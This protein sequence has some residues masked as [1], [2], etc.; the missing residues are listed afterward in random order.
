MRAAAALLLTLVPPSLA[1]QHS[2]EDCQKACAH[3]A[4]CCSTAIN[5]GSNQHLSCLQAC[6]VRVRG[7]HRAECEAHCQTR[8]C[9]LRINGFTY[10][11]CQSCTD[12]PSQGGSND[13][14]GTY[15]RC[16]HI[17]GASEDTCRAGCALG[18]DA[19]AQPPLPPPAAVPAG[20]CCQRSAS[21]DRCATW[22]YV[23]GNCIVLTAHT[24]SC[25]TGGAAWM[26]DK[27]FDEASGRCVVVGA[28]ASAGTSPSL[29]PPPPLPPPSPYFLAAGG[30][31]CV[32]ACATRAQ[33]CDLPRVT[34][35]AASVAQCRAVVSALGVTF[36]KSGMYPDDDS[37]CTYH[38]G[39][40]GWA[41]VMHTGRDQG[42][43]PAPTCAV[44]NRDRARRRVCACAARSPPL[45]SAPPPP[46]PVP[47]ARSAGCSCHSSNGARDE[48]YCEGSGIVDPDACDSDPR[49]HWGPFESRRCRAMVGR[50]EPPPPPQPGAVRIAVVHE[51]TVAG[52]LASFDAFAVQALEAAVRRTFPAALTVSLT[53]SA[54]SVRVRAKL[55]LPSAAEAQLAHATLARHSPASLSALLGITILAVEPPSMHASDAAEAGVAEEVGAAEV[56][57]SLLG[58]DASASSG[59][60]WAAANPLLLGALL[61]SAGVVGLVAA[62]AVLFAIRRRQRRAPTAAEGSMATSATTAASRRAPVRVQARPRHPPPQRRGAT[63]PVPVV[64]VAQPVVS[65]GTKTAGELRDLSEGAAPPPYKDAY[66]GSQAD[67]CATALALDALDVLDALPTDDERLSAG[68]CDEI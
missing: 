49:C 30:E 17:Y 29:A 34:A 3:D 2:L 12:V 11:R 26:A 64:V 24:I 41:Q 58:G 32:A 14:G 28:A 22:A 47:P 63:V 42:T 20:G 60:G 46:P 51:W 21:D 9:E 44:V 45:A 35:A 1:G 66:T 15:S 4:H 37:G 40:T 61:C 18:P 25:S 33:E 13:Y 8:G 7:T 67:C 50:L 54:A 48:A 62:A 5:P 68:R 19:A 56:E 57:M 43:V 39:Q 23:Y 36:T 65:D 16:S 59:A 31:S 38:P 27:Q 53:M 55:G 10:S 6:M 52:D